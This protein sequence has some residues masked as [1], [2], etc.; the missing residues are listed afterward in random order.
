M[1]PP[2]NAPEDVM[3]TPGDQD[4]PFQ[5]PEDMKT[6]PPAKPAASLDDLPGSDS[7][8]DSP[9]WQVEDTPAP[10]DDGFQASGLV[11]PV[12]EEEE[13]EEEDE[14]D[15]TA[16]ASA[17]NTIA[18]V[19]AATAVAA[20]GALALVL[21][22][23]Q[24]RDTTDDVNLVEEVGGVKVRRDLTSNDI[25]NPQDE[26]DKRLEELEEAKEEAK[27]DATEGHV[28]PEAG[29]AGDEPI[30]SQAAD[31]EAPE[32]EGDDDEPEVELNL[33]SALQ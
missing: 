10:P 11:M 4:E 33:G 15:G 1:V 29:E 18:L 13:E 31:D 25:P 8:A 28:P 9:S 16:S 6:L 21:L 27:E 24:P 20:M 5:I 32:T 7:S 17:M 23:T 12:E 19:V 26:L 22:M 2:S 30:S 14:E 3:A